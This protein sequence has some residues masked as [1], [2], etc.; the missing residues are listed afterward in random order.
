MK[1]SHKLVMVSAA[2]LMGV[3]PVLGMAENSVSVQAAPIAHA[4]GVHNTYGKNSRV[5]LTKTMKFVD[6]FGKNI[7]FR[8]NNFYD[9]SYNR[10]HKRPAA[11]V[12]FV[13]N[14]R[15]LV[16]LFELKSKFKGFELF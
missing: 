15:L 2:V 5:K 3:S 6:R 12:F 16:F 14:I 4:K 1:L 8:L 11:N 9:I 7:I 10:F 13:L